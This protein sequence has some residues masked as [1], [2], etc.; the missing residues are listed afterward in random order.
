MTLNHHR[1]FAIISIRSLSSHLDDSTI[2]PFIH[3]PATSLF[4]A[5]FFNLRVYDTCCIIRVRILLRACKRNVR[6][7]MHRRI[8]LLAASSFLAWWPVWQSVTVLVRD[9]YKF[10][11]FRPFDRETAR[12][13][14][15]VRVSIFPLLSSLP[16]HGQ[17]GWV[18]AADRDGFF[19]AP[20]VGDEVR[21]P[22]TSPADGSPCELRLPNLWCIFEHGSRGNE[23]RPTLVDF[24]R[25]INVDEVRVLSVTRCI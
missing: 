12:F 15:T 25:H 1:I 9:R 2:T 11:S 20:R 23:D 7:T 14:Q 17:V 8:Y 19:I 5:L 10:S 6:A 21:P 18:C 13:A 24:L 4:L 3:S 22:S 16:S